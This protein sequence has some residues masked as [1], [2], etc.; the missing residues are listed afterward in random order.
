MFGFSKNISY[1]YN[2]IK[3]DKSLVGKIVKVHLPQTYYKGSGV[4]TEASYIIGKCTFAGF[5]WRIGARQITI[6]RTPIFPVIE[7]QVEIL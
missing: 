5:N 2:M 4:S 7:S 6:N 1:L 3:I